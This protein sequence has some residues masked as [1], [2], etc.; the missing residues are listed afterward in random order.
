V[1]DGTDDDVLYQTYL[2][3]KGDLNEIR[4]EIPMPNGNY[5]VR[6]HLVENFWREPI[7]RVFSVKIEN[8]TRLANLDIWQEVGYRAALVK[9]FNVTLGDG[10]LNFTF[11]PTVNRLAIAGIEI[12]GST[13]TANALA[14]DANATQI[15][16]RHLRADRRHDYAGC[17]KRLDNEHVVQTGRQRHLPAR[18]HLRQPGGRH[19]HVLRPENRAGGCETSGVFTIGTLNNTLNFA[20]TATPIG[21]DAPSTSA[22]VSYITGGAGAGGYSVTWSNGQTGLTATGLTPGTYSVTVTD[23]TGCGRTQELTIARPANCVTALRINAGGAAQTVSGTTWSGCQT[24]NCQGYVTGGFVF[25]QSPMPVVSGVPANMNQA[26]FQTEWT[27]GQFGTN[28]VAVGAVAF[29]YNI[30]VPNGNYTVRLHFAELNKL[31][32]GQRTFDVDIEGTRRLDKFDIFLAAG[33]A[34]RAIVREFATTIADGNVSI[35]F[36]RQVE[37]AKVNAIEIIPVTGPAPVNALPVANAGNDQTVTL[38]TSTVT[39][40]GS[41]TDPDGTIAAFGWTPVT[42][43]VTTTLAT[44][45]AATTVISGLTAAGTYTFRLTV[46][47]NAGGTATDDV[48]V[49]VNRGNQVITFP[50][51][52]D[53]PTTAAPFNAGATTSAP[54]LAVTY[55]LVSGP[56]T[57]SAGGQITLTGTPGT[58]VVRASQAGDANY[59]AAADVDRSFNVVEST[60]TAPVLAVIGSQTVTAGATVTFTAS[61]TDG[62]QP[63]QTMTYALV[64]AP[65]GAVINAATGAFTWVTAA[66]GTFT[67]SVRVTDNGLPALSDE[68]PVT[69][70]VNPVATALRINAGGPAQ[71]V[72]GTTWTGCQTGNCNGYVTGGHVSRRHPCR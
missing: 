4:Y 71:T 39:V 46:T 54:G 24:G 42:T 23:G 31:A 30:P 50:A 6:L 63:A 52:T 8:E 7:K 55:S 60:N 65:Q 49:T 29:R 67:F 3:S 56:A 47:D 26:L 59:N 64:N 13:A 43:P 57:V 5:M 22:T 68:K 20:V 61:A 72:S 16:G 51:I 48:T 18:G 40:A 17:E 19:V 36:I 37:N 32:A 14:F 35:D 34:N 45:N 58:V 33:G 9:D 41:G 28:P 62:D 27:G 38:P 11:N 12:F 70:T 25:T 1:V 66:S 10:K 21:C 53:R 2:S 44:P 15:T 69:V